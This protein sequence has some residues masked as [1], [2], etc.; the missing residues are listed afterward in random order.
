MEAIEILLVEDNPDHAELTKRTLEDGNVG[1]QIHWVK[2]GQE[3]IDYLFKKRELYQR[4]TP[5][6]DPAGYKTTQTQW[7]RGLK[8]DQRRPGIEGHSCDHANHFRTGRRSL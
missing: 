6:P 5:R 8:K 2:D 4:P 3:A 7:H 1:N